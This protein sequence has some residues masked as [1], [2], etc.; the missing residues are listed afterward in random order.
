MIP[1]LANSRATTAMTAFTGRVSSSAL[2]AAG[3]LWLSGCV[4]PYQGCVVPGSTYEPHGPP[5][6][7][8]QRN[9]PI[10][11]SPVEYA[12]RV[13]MAPPPFG[14]PNGPVM[15]LG[16]PTEASPVPM[17]APAPVEWQPT[18]F[19]PPGPQAQT[20]PP[21]APPA[22]TP[23]VPSAEA[24]QLQSKID[25]LSAQI[26]ALDRRTQEQAHAL[27]SAQRDAQTARQTTQRLETE[28]NTW[29]TELN[30]VRQA[31]QDQSTADL[32]ALDEL[33]SVLEQ[34]VPEP[35]P[36]EPHPFIE[37]GSHM[38][39]GRPQGVRR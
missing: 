1:T 10:S 15:E 26:A 20:F 28:F 13:D 31:I 33:N 32:Q 36:P 27:D 18:P 17:Q 34:L 24:A 6:A 38:A 5:A 39:T 3:A 14:T 37:D 21:Q 23:P 35:T 29:R 16:V 8:V 30:L 11:P 22:E 19:V 7:W 4:S 12:Q 9:I 2:L 25:Q